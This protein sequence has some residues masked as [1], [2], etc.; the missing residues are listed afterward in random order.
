MS[1]V[2]RPSTFVGDPYYDS[3]EIYGYERSGWLTFAGL[4]I[5]FVGMWNAFEG[6]IGL[7]R[8]A[9]FS[10]TP[11]FGTVAFWSLV[12]IGV[13]ILEMSIAYAI[14]SGREWARWA[15][16]IIVAANALIEMLVIPLYPWWALIVIGLNALI[17]FALAAKWPPREPAMPPA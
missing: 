8:S 16:I 4:M 15:G 9:Y 5:L 17:L 2:E 3:A 13:G 10:G 6:F 14:F 7:F 11:V 1:Y 12:W